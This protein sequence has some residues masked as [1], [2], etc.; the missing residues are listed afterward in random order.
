MKKKKSIWIDEETIADIEKEAKERGSKFAVIANERMKHR[1]D[2]SYGATPYIRARTQ[3][4]INLC[5]L[6]KFDEAQEEA[7]KL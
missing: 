2:E 5:R 3:D 4:V 1:V 7:N 6:G